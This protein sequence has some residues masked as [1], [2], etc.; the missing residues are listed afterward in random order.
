MERSTHHVPKPSCNIMRLSRRAP[1]PIRG[2]DYELQTFTCR[3][4]QHQ[5]ER[6]AD[7]GGE[8]ADDPPALI[9]MGFA[10]S[11]THPV[12]QRPL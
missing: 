10:K 5:I 1:H 8:V 2:Y 9:V 12:C 11:E 3:I 7:I 4:C 6:A